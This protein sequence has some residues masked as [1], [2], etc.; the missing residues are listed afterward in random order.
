MRIAVAADRAGFPLK[1][2]AI[3]TARSAGHETTDIG[4]ENADNPIDY[5][6]TARWAADAIRNGDAEGGRGAARPAAATPDDAT[7]P[8]PAA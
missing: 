1:Q 8:G 5:P 7:P 4:P 3:D 6:D 2:L